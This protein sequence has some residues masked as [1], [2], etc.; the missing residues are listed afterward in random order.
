VE[1]AGARGAEDGVGQG[2]GFGECERDRV[3]EKEKNNEIGKK[4]SEKN[5]A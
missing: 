2:D 5:T 3:K 1:P 4:N